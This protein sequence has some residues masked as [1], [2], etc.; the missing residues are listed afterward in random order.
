MAGGDGEEASSTRR[1]ERAA[2]ADAVRQT[3]RSA[4]DSSGSHRREKTRPEMAAT[5]KADEDTAGS[6]GARWRE[7]RAAAEGSDGRQREKAAAA[8]DGSSKIRSEEN[9]RSERKKRP[10]TRLAMR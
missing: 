2:H 4:A 5:K 10:R 3:R 1:C 7:G 8:G 6:S 9:T